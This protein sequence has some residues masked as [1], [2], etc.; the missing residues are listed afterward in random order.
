MARN[1]RYLR[2][3]PTELPAA[4]DAKFFP[5]LPAHEGIV[6]EE[7]VVTVRIEHSE[8]AACMYCSCDMAPHMHAIALGGD[9]R[10]S[11]RTGWRV[12][13]AVQRCSLPHKCTHTRTHAYSTH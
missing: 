4:P 6:Y 11:R 8:D 13:S 5:G 9:V 7:E 2:L 1:I 10:Q 12:N 3:P